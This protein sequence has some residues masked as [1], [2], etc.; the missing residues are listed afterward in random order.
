M[1]DWKGRVRI[2]ANSCSCIGKRLFDK[3]V[4]ETKNENENEKPSLELHSHLNIINKD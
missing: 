3:M 1:Q 4:N 2:T